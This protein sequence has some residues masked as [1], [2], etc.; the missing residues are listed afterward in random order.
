MKTKYPTLVN[1]VQMAHE[2]PETFTVPDTR[3]VRKGWWVK[4][5]AHDRERFWVEV[6]SR[7]GSVLTGRIDNQL[8]CCLDLAFNDRIAFH[9]DNIYS[10]ICPHEV[11]HMKRN[12]KRPIRNHIPTENND[13]T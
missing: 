2:H 9:T 3:Q 4:V 13:E 1:A 5:C 8:V 11:R 6:L 12:Y 7:K 10:T